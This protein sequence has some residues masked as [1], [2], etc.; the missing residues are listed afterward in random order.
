[1][2][3]LAEMTEYL[4]NDLCSALRALDDKLK[5]HV[6]AMDEKPTIDA[7]ASQPAAAAAPAAVVAGGGNNDKRSEKVNY[8][9][10]CA[11]V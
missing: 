11:V 2:L 9:C 10:A 1:V 8:S 5:A 3:R 4:I 7:A 6:E